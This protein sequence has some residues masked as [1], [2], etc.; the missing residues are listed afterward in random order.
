MKNQLTISETTIGSFHHLPDNQNQIELNGFTLRQA[1]KA[2]RD[3]DFGNIGGSH[4]IDLSDGTFLDVCMKT[5]DKGNTYEMNSQR[6][7]RSV[8]DRYEGEKT[9]RYYAL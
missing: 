4:N 7:R 9:I 6:V 1:L 5:Y 2:L 8:Y 3:M